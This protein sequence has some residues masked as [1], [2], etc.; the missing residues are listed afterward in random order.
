[1]KVFKTTYESKM[2]NENSDVNLTVEYGHRQLGASL[3]FWEEDPSKELGKGQ[4]KNLKLDFD[5]IKKHKTLIIKSEMA[6]ANERSNLMNN[7][8][9][10]TSDSQ[11]EIFKPEGRV[12]QDKDKAEFITWIDF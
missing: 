9:T 7:I 2:A 5:K 8:I 3:I 11:K 12:D 6:D 10:F 1:M 4:I